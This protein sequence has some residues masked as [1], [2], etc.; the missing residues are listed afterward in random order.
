MHLEICEKKPGNMGNHGIL[1][2]RKSGNPAD[3]HLGPVITEN[4]DVPNATQ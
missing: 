4:V 1:S 3:N 2:L